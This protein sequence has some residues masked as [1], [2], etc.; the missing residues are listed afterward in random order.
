MKLSGPIDLIKKSFQFF[1]DKKNLIFFLKIYSPLAVLAVV[2]FF[3][4]FFLSSQMR[5]LG[6]P[7]SFL[8]FVQN[9]FFVLPSLGVGILEMIAGFWIGAA[10]IKAV[11][12]AASGKTLQVREVYVFAWKKMWGFVLLG[13]VLFLIILGGTIL[14][15]IPG[16]IFSIWFSFS[17]FIYLYDGLGI[18]ESLQRSR[19]LIKGRFW[20]VTGRLFVIGLLMA[21]FQSMVSGVPFV[22]LV[23]SPLLGALILLPSY[24]LYLELSAR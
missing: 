3:Q 20:P 10:G 19:E 8:A 18:K 17:K 9:P 22:G 16:I 1:F 6:T 23:I 4:S 5:Q 24:F 2:S 15:I 14:L 11:N 12:D 21:I 13:I 7:E